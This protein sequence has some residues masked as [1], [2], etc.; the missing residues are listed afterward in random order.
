MDNRYLVLNFGTQSSLRKESK[1]IPYCSAKAGM[2]RKRTELTCSSIRE[3]VL[4][5][6]RALLLNTGGGSAW[7]VARVLDMQLDQSEHT[8]TSPNICR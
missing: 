1:G 2:R 5:P 8:L 6:S 4:S 3:A 7:R